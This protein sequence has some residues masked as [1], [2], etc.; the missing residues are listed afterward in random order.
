MVTGAAEAIARAYQLFEKPRTPRSVGRISTIAS[1]CRQRPV[2]APVLVSSCQ[3]ERAQ[4]RRQRGVHRVRGH[5][6]DGV[7]VFRGPDPGG[8]RVG[9][10]HAH[11]ATAHE[12]QFVQHRFEQAHDACEQFA[13]GVSHGGAGAAW[14]SSSRSAS[15]RSRAR[16]SRRASTSA[17]NSY[18]AG[19][20]RIANGTILCSGSRL[21]PRT[22]PSGSGQTG[23]KS[24]PRCE[25]AIKWRCGVRGRDA[26]GDLAALSG[27][28]VFQA[29][30]EELLD[31]MDDWSS[32]VGGAGDEA[33]LLQPLERGVNLRRTKAEVRCQLRPWS[34]VADAPVMSL[35]RTRTS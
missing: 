25:V 16:P 4:P 6:D 26:A 15:C 7:D 11:G 14:W 35:A 22:S 3:A 34:G 10:H 27:K 24:A 5:V 8:G 19:S 20:F 9:D 33:R 29:V 32:A 2:G 31:G 30:D 13:I 28:D 1:P 18:K 17:S 12:Y 23:G 21:A